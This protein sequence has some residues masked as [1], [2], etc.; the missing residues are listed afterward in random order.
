MIKVKDVVVTL[1]LNKLPK[2]FAADLL[3]SPISNCQ[4]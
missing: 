2:Q 4:K 1:L 3:D